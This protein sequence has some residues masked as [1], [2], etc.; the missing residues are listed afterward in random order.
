MDF[1]SCIMETSLHEAI[2]F[3]KKHVPEKRPNCKKRC[4]SNISRNDMEPWVRKE[5]GSFDVTIG[6]YDG[7]E[8]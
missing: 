4:R 2:K 8:V 1:Y 6:E 3:A 7:A 5:G